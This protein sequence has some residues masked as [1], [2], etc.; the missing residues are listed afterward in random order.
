MTADILENVYSLF[1]ELIEGVDDQLYMHI[2]SDRKDV[3]LSAPDFLI[4]LF[5][6]S[7][8]HMAGNYSQPG[9]LGKDLMYRGIEIIPTHEMAI[10]LFHKDYPLYNADWMVNKISLIPAVENQKGLYTERIISLRNHFNFKVNT[11][12]SN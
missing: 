12:R 3:C 1:N 9:Q 7:L 4:K 8:H 11:F 5:C 2:N 6:Q 10:T